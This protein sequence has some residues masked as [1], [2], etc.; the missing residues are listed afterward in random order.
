MSDAQPAPHSAGLR[1]G[2][3]PRP[4]PPLLRLAPA[5]QPREAHPLCSRCARD[6]PVVPAMRDA[7]ALRARTPPTALSSDLA[8][9]LAH[10]TATPSP[11]LS[12]GLPRA[13][14]ALS[15]PHPRWLYP[16]PSAPLASLASRRRGLSSRASA[17]LPLNHTPA[18]PLR[19]HLLAPRSRSTAASA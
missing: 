13:P 1:G 12:A 14:C 4:E 8:L 11:N 6:H 7:R 15:A 17:R 16:S 5:Y 3:A 9:T 10:I 19:A 2:R 18:M